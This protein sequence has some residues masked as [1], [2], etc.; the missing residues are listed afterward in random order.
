M[1]NKTYF[2]SAAGGFR[3]ELSVDEQGDIW[4]NHFG[5]VGCFSPEHIQNAINILAE[6]I[7]KVATLTDKPEPV[8]TFEMLEPGEVYQLADG[9][10]SDTNP[11]YVKLDDDHVWGCTTNQRYVVKEW[12]LQRPV[13]VVIHDE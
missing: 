6:S 11:L 9:V 4:M 13:R 1:S 2:E 10:Q 12:E 5:G 8:L 7:G 3:V